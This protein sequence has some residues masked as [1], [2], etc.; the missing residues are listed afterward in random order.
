[1]N[2]WHTNN[3]QDHIPYLNKV[4]PAYIRFYDVSRTPD[5]PV[6]KE[7]NPEKRVKIRIEPE[8]NSLEIEFLYDKNLTGVLERMGGKATEEKKNCWI[9]KNSQAISSKLV[10]Y[11]KKYHYKIDIENDIEKMQ[12]SAMQ[13]QQISQSD[14]KLRKGLTSLNYSKRTIDQYVSHAHNF[15]IFSENCNLNSFKLINSYIEEITIC[16]NYSR[17]YQNLIINSIKAYFRFVQ[18]I[19]LEKSDLPRPRRYNAFPVILTENEI[20]RIL[21]AT[22]NLKHRT[23]ISLI[24]ETGITISEVVCIKLSDIDYRNKSLIIHGKKQVRPRV[25]PLSDSILE[26]LNDYVKFYKPGNFLFEGYGGTI[27]TERAIQ[28]AFKKYVRKSGITKNVSVHNLRHS[29]AFRM[30]TEGKDT[31]TLQNFLGN[32]SKRSTEIYQKA[33]AA[34]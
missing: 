12:K 18:G 16:R 33:F 31:I 19:M 29:C 1:M 28:K 32:T 25:L 8:G 11:L 22:P 17:S 5:I 6:I 3:I 15:L 21:H 27:I 34:L 4:F 26:N 30:A 13:I 9:I 7:D 24:Y 14:N 10:C 2:S 23:I 20:Q